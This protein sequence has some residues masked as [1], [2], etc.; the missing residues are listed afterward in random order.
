MFFWGIVLIIFAILSFIIIT[1]GGALDTKNKIENLTQIVQEFYANECSTGTP[2][3]CID[4]KYSRNS[5]AI[6]IFHLAN[7]MN[8]LFIPN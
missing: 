5:L 2:Q 4:S 8:F 6:A 1:G 3:E 7:G